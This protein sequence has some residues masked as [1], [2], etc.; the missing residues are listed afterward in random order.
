MQND[1]DF[2]NDDNNIEDNHPDFIIPVSVHVT[3]V[4]DNIPQF[5]GKTP[6]QLN[7]SEL[8]IVSLCTF[9]FVV[10]VLINIPYKSFYKVIY[11]CKS[12]P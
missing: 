10:Y 7:I 2:E 5:V 8:T 6:Y 3:D 11:T 1:V 9:I 4:N 12:Y